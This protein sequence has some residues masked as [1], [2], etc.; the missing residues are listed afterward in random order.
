MVSSGK[1]YEANI[2]ENADGGDENQKQAISFFKSYQGKSTG[3]RKGSVDLRKGIDSRLDTIDLNERLNLTVTSKLMLEKA[4][5]LLFDVFKF[6][7]ATDEKELY[8]LTSYLLHKHNIFR[9][10]KMDPEI[11]FKFITR[12]QDYYNPGFIEYHNKT[13]GA[14]VCQTTYFFLNGCDLQ[15]VCEINEVEYG[16][17]LI[18]AA[19]HDFEHFG[20]NNN[21]LIDSRLP[22]AIEYNDKS[23]LENHHIASTF[24]IIQQKEFN[25]FQDLNVDEFK[26]VRKLM[27][28]L[29]LATDAALHFTELGKFKSRVGADDFSPAKDDK[30]SVLKMAM[31]LADISNP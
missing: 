1:L 15:T 5:T 22:W 14:D 31:H 7:D 24:S 17:I 19:C 12:V 4:N 20:Y 27:I 6:K 10:M 18:A 29:V 26:D 30:L 16:S 23:P 9:E 8:V 13:H 28:E 2:D 21:F 11:F 25:I 3:T